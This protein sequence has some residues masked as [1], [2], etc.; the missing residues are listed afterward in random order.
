MLSIEQLV[1]RY[2]ERNPDKYA[3]ISDKHKMTY[4][5]LIQQ[6]DCIV[7]YLSQEYNVKPGDHIIIEATKRNEFISTYLASHLLSAVAIILDYETT[8]SRL[9]YIINKTNPKI[10]LGKFKNLKNNPDNN[11]YELISEIKSL[12]KEIIHFK[13]KNY[14]IDNVADILFT[15]GT[16]G[17]P[18][19]VQ[20]TNKNIASAAN[21]INSFMGTKESDVELLAL[22]VS[23]SFGLGR[24]RCLL[25]IGA[26]IISI[27]GFTNIKRYFTSITKHSVTGLAFVPSAWAYLNKMSG[28]KIAEYKDHIRYIEIG[29][30]PMSTS[31]KEVL[32]DLLPN[33]KIC[34]HYGLTE[35]SRSTFLDF[36]QKNKLHTVGKASPNVDIKIADSS[37]KELPVEVEGEIIIKGDHVC[38]KYVDDNSIS[39]YFNGEY[40]RTGDS[41]IM[42]KDGYIRLLGRN[43]EQINVGGK[44]VYPQ[45]IENIINLIDHISESACVG[46][47]DENGIMGEVVKAYLVGDQSMIEINTIKSIV[48]AKLEQYKWPIS[49]EWISQIPKTDSGKLQ[50]HKL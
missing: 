43:K 41:G 49:Y 2:A 18:R 14:S 27:N 50:R 6:V 19:G 25:S 35:A 21:N 12:K 44:K 40:I 7:N 4:S 13:Y 45:E 24:I 33:T 38:T 31:E 29:S 22:P 23:H 48:Q 47:P 34:M 28:N 20:L 36:S 42:D 11:Y 17:L 15:S 37:G 46:Y 39:Q 9:E 30:A 32:I 3:L 5:E 1:F 26:T 16:T 10:I 8:E